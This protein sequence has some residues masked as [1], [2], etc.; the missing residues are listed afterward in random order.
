MTMAQGPP[1]PSAIKR[2][3]HNNNHPKTI[4][5]GPPPRQPVSGN[6]S[7]ASSSSS[8]S[9][10][11][12]M[13]KN[14][15][16]G[17][18]LSPSP[19]LSYGD[20]SGNSAPS[21]LVPSNSSFT[22]ASSIIPRLPSPVHS[23]ASPLEAT[24][25]SSSS[26]STTETKGRRRAL[27]CVAA[28]ISTQT[29]QVK[30]EEQES[31]KN[32]LMK[33]EEE[34]EGQKPGNPLAGA[35][36]DWSTAT[37]PDASKSAPSLLKTSTSSSSLHG[38]SNSIIALGNPSSS[39]NLSNMNSRRQKR[40]ERN[41][42]SARLSRR[43]RK[44]YLEVLEERVSMLSEEMDRGRCLHVDHAL[45]AYN[46]LRHS[47]LTSTSQDLCN[48]AKQLAYASRTSDELRVAATFQKEQL[49]SMVFPTV[50]KFTLWLTLQNDVY[51]RGGRAASE[52][53]SAARIGERIF[54]ENKKVSSLSQHMWPLVCNEIGLSYDQEER[55]RAYQRNILTNPTSFLHRHTAHASKH[56]LE[57][58]HQTIQVVNELTRQREAKVLSIL[59]LPQQIKYLQYLHKQKQEKS[60]QQQKAMVSSLMKSVLKTKTQDL[61]TCPKERHVAAN[62]YIINHQLKNMV[63][64]DLPKVAPIIS[65]KSQ[66]KKLSRRP[67]FESLASSEHH[68]H[69]DH[70]K[71]SSLK[72]VSSEISV[73]EMDSSLHSGNHNI[74]PI[75]P[76]EVAESNASSLVQE[77]LGSIMSIIPPMP[78]S[79]TTT[80]PAP[81]PTTYT[82]STAPVPPPT[83]PSNS[84]PLTYHPQAQPTPFS[85]LPNTAPTP[86]TSIYQQPQQFTQ[87]TS[88]NTKMNSHFVPQDVF[89]NA[90]V[91]TTTIPA[92]TPFTSN[93]TYQQTSA[94]QPQNTMNM[95]Y[96]NPSGIPSSVT[97]TQSLQNQHNGPGKTLLKTTTS[98]GGIS[99]ASSAGTH[100]HHPTNQHITQNQ[101]YH[102]P[103]QQHDQQVYQHSQQQQQ[104]PAPPVAHQNTNTQPTVNTSYQ[105]CVP[106]PVMSMGTQSRNTQ[107]P[108]PPNNPIASQPAPLLPQR[109]SNYSP[110]MM[111]YSIPEICPPP[112][113]QV[114]STN[115][116]NPA[117]DFLFELK[118]EDWAIG[119][120]FDD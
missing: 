23:N 22:T 40:L 52:R 9:S 54:S 76:P 43:R 68:T 18:C 93:T 97:T 5:E 2:H 112:L 39:N 70:E 10:P 47:L 83:Q 78:Q 62:L 67:S 94:T 11:S 75:L 59:T 53:L 44:Q 17:P 98:G 29:S 25:S 89:S 66:L 105:S 49:S 33:L 87:P 48:L 50:N 60:Q 95:H 7:S 36:L 21:S 104:A 8:T 65:N 74:G 80:I 99:M 82:T 12:Y 81:Q 106:N 96:T 119:E 30:A 32:E 71:K 45:T 77:T 64:K 79:F 92:P 84:A 103:T 31:T 46:Q 58:M 108:P 116:P 117:D 6:S 56:V 90:N 4:D 55:F 114:I 88:V 26:S 101:Q 57:S 28:P 107:P 86:I 69:P 42:E 85:T 72:R 73:D 61:K 3:C 34:V 37:V 100:Y 15:N 110:M 102:P 27:S 35:P 113:G 109:T 13:N 19:E 1:N 51:F 38:S 91:T 41:R 111:D 16:H 14:N 115:L 24:T 118:E 120:G 20:Q 63:L